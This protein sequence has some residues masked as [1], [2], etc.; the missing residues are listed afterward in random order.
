MTLDKING[1]PAILCWDEDNL[2]VVISMTLSDVGIQEIFAILNPDKL[3][4]L[5]KQISSS[6]EQSSFES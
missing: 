4:Y 2:V 6:R 1:N 3:A 5:R